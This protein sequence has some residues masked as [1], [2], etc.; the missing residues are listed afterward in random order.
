MSLSRPAFALVLVLALGA[1]DTSGPK[2]TTGTDGGANLLATQFG[3][4]TGKASA[5]G[6]GP[7]AG[8]LTGG[9]LTAA[10][11]SADRAAAQGAALRAYAAPIGETITW[12][13]PKSGSLG[14][15]TPTKDGYL[16]DRTYCREFQETI[17]VGGTR[18]R[19]YG[20]ACRQTDGSW[21][22]VSE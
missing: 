1:C 22:L 11:D 14:S 8:T 13:N 7:L 12:N 17:T 16:G 21:K 19:G 10:L 9:A 15:V 5:A 20:T 18:K 2:Q 4:G 6:L 3:H